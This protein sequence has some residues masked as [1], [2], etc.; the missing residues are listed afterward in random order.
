YQPSSCSDVRVGQRPVLELSRVLALEPQRL[1]I[2]TLE[3]GDT[4]RERQEMV[5]SQLEQLDVVMRRQRLAL[6]VGKLLP[7]AAFAIRQVQD[8]VGPLGFP[9]GDGAARVFAVALNQLW[10]AVYAVEELVEE[11]LAH[12]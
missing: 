5:R 10:V 12:A 3:Q 11:V 9:P 1:R 4:E 7:G 6:F 8:D 2:V